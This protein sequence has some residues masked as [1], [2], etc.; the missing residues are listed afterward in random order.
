MRADTRRW[1]A[2]LPSERGVG[3]EGTYTRGVGENVDLKPSFFYPC[4]TSQLV[5]TVRE[6]LDQ[7]RLRQT[8]NLVRHAHWDACT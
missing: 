5:G 8:F 4:E 7:F 3:L 1:F 2:G 6:P